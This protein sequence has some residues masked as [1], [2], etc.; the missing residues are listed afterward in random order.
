M[1]GVDGAR[2]SDSRSRRWMQMLAIGLVAGLT[3]LVPALRPFLAGLLVLAGPLTVYGGLLA[4]LR[5]HLGMR[6]AS[7]LMAG[8][9]CGALTPL[10]LGLAL[11]VDSS[12]ATLIVGLAGVACSAL[13]LFFAAA[14][15]TR[16]RTTTERYVP[17]LDG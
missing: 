17:P 7:R 10:L 1:T 13:A 11:I 4:F 6:S 15:F 8:L 12:T 3:L 9:V 2:A 14:A 16:E 5:G